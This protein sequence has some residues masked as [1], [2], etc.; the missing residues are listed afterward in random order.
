MKM[1]LV[2]SKVRARNRRD[3]IGEARLLHE[4][5]AQFEVL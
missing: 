1:Q 4:R 3:L 2:R 5:R